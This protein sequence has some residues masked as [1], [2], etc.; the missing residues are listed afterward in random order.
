M[1]FRKLLR[2]ALSY[3]AQFI[4]MA[5]WCVYFMP[6]IC[7]NAQNT[8]AVYLNNVRAY[9]LIVTFCGHREVHEPKK[10]KSLAGI[11]RR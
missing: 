3:K 9:D 1:L 6:V 10:S 7:Y 11:G 4:S 8:Y 2:T 5:V